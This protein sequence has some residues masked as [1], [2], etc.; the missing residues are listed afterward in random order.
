MSAYVAGPRDHRWQV[1]L[2]WETALKIAGGLMAAVIIGLAFVIWPL[3]SLYGLVMRNTPWLV[4]IG[5]GLA[6][7]WWTVWRPIQA[8]RKAK[9]S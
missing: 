9:R 3:W 7:I 8:Y 5:F 2:P 1:I 6:A 4:M